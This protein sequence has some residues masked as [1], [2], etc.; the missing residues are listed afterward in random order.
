MSQSYLANIQLRNYAALL[1]P[2]RQ[3]FLR[4]ATKMDD[5]YGRCTKIK[6][7]FFRRRAVVILELTSKIAAF[8]AI[9]HKSL[10]LSFLGLSTIESNHG[11]N[12]KYLNL[13]LEQLAAIIT[14][15]WSAKINNSSGKGYYI[16]GKLTKE[17]YRED[18]FFDGPD[19]DMPVRGLK[20]Y[21]LFA[22]Q[23]FNHQKSRADLLRPV[24]I[25][26]DENT[27][28]A[29]WRIEGVIN[30]PWKPHVKP[31]TGHTVYHLDENNLVEKHIEKWDITVLDAF[32]SVIFPDW[33][34][35]A[36]PA[37]PVITLVN[38]E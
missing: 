7:P 17:I 37:P 26:R 15:D 36:P 4:H 9:R 12:P 25:D 34:F 35:G 31:W 1:Q 8:I 3:S 16:T 20:K 22:S 27:L 24:E 19:P 33:N 38:I 30:L 10:P 14:K 2:A 6:C 18:C 23:L 21:L 28:I 5:I 29:H 32:I 13:E 11:A